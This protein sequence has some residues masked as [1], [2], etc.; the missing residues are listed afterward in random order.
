[1]FKIL[2]KIYSSFWVPF[3]GRILSLFIKLIEGNEPTE[4]PTFDIDGVEDGQSKDNI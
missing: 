4:K 2:R 3:F 1:M